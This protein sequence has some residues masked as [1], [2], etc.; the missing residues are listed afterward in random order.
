[1]LEKVGAPLLSGVFGGDVST[2]SVRAVMAA[3]VAM[4]QQHGSLIEGLRAATARRGTAKQG[5]LFT[6]LKRGLGSLVDAMVATIPEAWIRR[7]CAVTAVRREANGWQVEI[8]GGSEG[9]DALLMAAPVDVAARLLGA[10]DAR[11]AEL[12]QLEASSAVV[13]GLAFDQ[14]FALPQGFGF[15][16][17]PVIGD[18]QG[19]DDGPQAKSRL[20]AATFMDQKYGHR[21]PEGGR[22]LRGFFGGATAEALFAAS[23]AEIAAQTR[24]E[25]EAVLGF[26]LPPAVVTVVR[27]WPRSLP[28]YAVGHLERMEELFGRVRAL[29]GLWLLGNGYRGVGLPDLA[30]DA[31]AAAREAVL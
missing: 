16:V 9:F 26:A 19:T 22:L 8:A 29:G 18:K 7:E 27:R 30:R 10:T 3:F 25:L 1:V 13:V 14:H 4:E 31:R 24:T 5:S 15:L 2:L 28:Q 21:V 12:M 17:P 23:D 20:L 11:A 6:T